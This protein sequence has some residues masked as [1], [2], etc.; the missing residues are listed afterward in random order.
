M[1]F[2][3]RKNSAATDD[4]IDAQ[5]WNENQRVLSGEFNGFLDRD[6]LPESAISTEYIEKKACNTFYAKAQPEYLVD[7]EGSHWR[8]V[9]SQEFEAQSDGVVIFSW[10]CSYEW[11]ITTSMF[12]LLSASSEGL[13]HFRVLV[14]GVVAS[15][16]MNHTWLKK[17]ETVYMTGAI[18]ITGGSVSVEGQ[19]KKIAKDIG[20]GGAD[21]SFAG[22]EE[23]IK[24]IADYGEL[25]VQYKRR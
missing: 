14:N 15:N 19:I 22:M 17:R 8:S 16:S 13:A 2:R 5:N 6:N 7:G 25:I 12:S 24:V 20:S 4:A 23:E 21:T 9:I 10:G 11:L 1:A 18:P 3:Y